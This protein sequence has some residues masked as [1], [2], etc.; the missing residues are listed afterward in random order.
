MSAKTAQSIQNLKK[1]MKSLEKA[2][3]TP[4]VEDRDYAGIIQNF[5]FVY[6]LTWK[7]LKRIL[8]SEGIE[9]SFPR[10]VFEE[11][12]KRGL[13]EGNE[14]WKLIIEARNLS[15][16]TYDEAL[17]KKLCGQIMK[18]FL[19]IFQKTVEKISLSFP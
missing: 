2:T 7:S 11:S 6:E 5:E 18:D 9:A 19:P 15:V 16:H 8:E 13:I 17:A 12:F 1:A 14:V 3:A 4:P 10:I